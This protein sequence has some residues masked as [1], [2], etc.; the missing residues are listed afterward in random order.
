MAQIGIKLADGSFFS[1]LEDTAVG[2]KRVVLSVAQEGQP[3]VQ[4]DLLR[5][6]DEGVQ[7]YVGCLVLEDVSAEGASALELLVG[8]DE[9]RTINAEIREP[10]G[11][12]YQSISVGI[13]KLS[14]I[15]SFDLPEE[16]SIDIESVDTLEDFGSEKIDLPDFESSYEDT[17]EPEFDSSAPPPD[18][19]FDD[20]GASDGEYHTERPPRPY[21]AISVVALVIVVVSLVSLGAYAMFRWLQTEPLPELRAAILA[22][23][24][25]R[26]RRRTSR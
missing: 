10:G 23:P 18:F 13:D 21:Y 1:V 12:Q 9:A 17:G 3:T 19:D 26:L 16:E 5:R 11:R 24:L 8:I 20:E 7:Q 2:R 6:S 25:R 15:S 4:V 14:E 22:M